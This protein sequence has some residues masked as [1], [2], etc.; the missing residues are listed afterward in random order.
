MNTEENNIEQSREQAPAVP[1]FLGVIEGFINTEWMPTRGFNP[2]D[3]T[4][5]RIL[6]S[7][8]IIIDLADMVDLELNDVAQAMIYLGYRT[9]VYE[10]KV[11]WLLERRPNK[12]GL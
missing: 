1:K 9:I 6:T 4:R 11:G 10:G 12:Y 7:Q 8:E 3:I 5:F 2:D